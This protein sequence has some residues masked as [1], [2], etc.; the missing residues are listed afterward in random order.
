MLLARELPQVSVPE[1]F[2]AMDLDLARVNI[3]K[4]AYHGFA[5]AQVKMGA[6]YE[7]CQL[8]CD[9]NPALSLHYNVL[10]ARQ[11]EAE[12]EMAISKWFLCGH[13][14]VFEKNDELAFTYAQRAA[15]SGLPTAEFA[16][17]Y[18]YEVG[19]YVQ[20]DI[21]EARSW[22]AKA[23][24]SGN[25]DAS[26]R[27]ECISRSKTLS[28][29]DHEKV[30]ISRIKSTR[31]TAHQRGNS[32]ESTPQQQTIQMPDPS[33]ITLSDGPSAAASY[34]DRPQ[35][36]RPRPPQGYQ[37]SDPRPS[38]AFGVNPNLR[39]NAPTGYGGPP[40][41]GSR[42]PSYGPGG[43]GPGP[44]SMNYR[45]PGTGTPLS[46][47]AGPASPQIS[48]MSTPT[49]PPRLDIGYSAPMP[50]PGGRRPPPRVD[51]AAL[52]RKPARPPVSAQSGVPSPRQTASPSFPARAESRQPSQG[53]GASTPQ[54]APS[55]ASSTSS[56]PP[57]Q[58]P[59]NPTKS[60]AP[61]GKGPKTFEEMGV[62]SAK[63]DND[64]V[65]FHSPLSSLLEAHCLVD[66]DVIPG[67]LFLFNL[68]RLSAV[69]AYFIPPYASSL[70]NPG[71]SKVSVVRGTNLVSRRLGGSLASMHLYPGF[72][73]LFC[74]LF[75]S[76]SSCHEAL[77]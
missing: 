65:S 52:D 75:I 62:P 30:A 69:S 8:D 43:P 64:C 21:K 5:K 27:I 73:A 26:G 4:A 45:R 32:L 9:F 17:G 13:E 11:G 24:A 63:N 53:S 44:N 10:A 47:P 55:V 54:P 59:V 51:S 71:V 33:R 29:K 40:P 38:S 1:S 58:K 67:T 7:L 31:Y 46:A 12:A 60:Q 18:F 15:Q 37:L 2:L 22:Y 39:Q 57:Q 6:A 49:G 42:T 48:G 14:G 28:R 36:A 68:R 16:L 72:S 34:P 35:S 50:P 23:A 77:I 70:Y 61:P 66:C 20:P 74:F 25:K 3:E 76:L 41:P 56:A 19:I